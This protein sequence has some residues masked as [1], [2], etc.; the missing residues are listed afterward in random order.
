MVC[1]AEEIVRVMHAVLFAAE[2]ARKQRIV[3]GLSGG[4]RS[5]LRRDWECEFNESTEQMILCAYFPPI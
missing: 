2:E 5:E 4:D 1:D 3:V